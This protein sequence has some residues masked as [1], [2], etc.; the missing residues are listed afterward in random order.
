[1]VLMWGVLD[2]RFGLAPYQKLAGQLLAAGILTL[3][4]VQV[5]ITRIDWL[6]ILITLI[7]I[8]GLTNAFNLV[9]SMDG[10]ALGL[11]GIAAAF[12]MLVTI[13]ASQPV[14]AE[15]SAAVLGAAAG[16]FYFNV[17]PAR[18]F[19]GDSGSQL[20]GFVLAAIGIAYVPGQAGL[21][22]GVSWF[23]PILVMGVPI[24]DTSLVVISRLRRR[25]PIFQ[26]YQDH[27]YHRLVALGLDSTRSVIAMQLVAVMLGLVAFIALDASVLGA[28]LIFGIIFLVGF[29]I[30]IVLER[31]SF[32]NHFK[33]S[34]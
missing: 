11:G 5:H 25:E 4:D 7:W 3:F 34:Q 8:V 16:A 10:L 28:N 26:A 33:R 12:F 22:Q 1:V 14:L 9:D 2:D 19:L 6:D 31:I 20:L 24:F 30:M 27:T 23:T 21:P 15:L 17:F 13:D 29:V 32:S 18:M